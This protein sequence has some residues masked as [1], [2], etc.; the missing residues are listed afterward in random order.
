MS[1]DAEPRPT[2]LGRVEPLVTYSTGVAVTFFTEI[3]GPG[4]K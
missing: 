3:A 2:M 1:V 4:S